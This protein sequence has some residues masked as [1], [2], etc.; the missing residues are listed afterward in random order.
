MLSEEHSS[1]NETW[2]TTLE[3]VSKQD[4]DL[5]SYAGD[6]PC[7]VLSGE[8]VRVDASFGEIDNN[9]NNFGDS[10]DNDYGSDCQPAPSVCSAG[11]HSI[12]NKMFPNATTVN[13]PQLWRKIRCNQEL[14]IRCCNNGKPK[15]YDPKLCADC[16]TGDSSE[17]SMCGKPREPDPV[18]ISQKL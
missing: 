14:V 1:E 4:T 9:N 8:G 16:D 17:S 12:L 10:E 18:A 2:T 15:A 6:R 13:S 3:E 11:K 5:Y 7:F